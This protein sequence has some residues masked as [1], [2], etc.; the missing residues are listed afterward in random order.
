MRRKRFSRWPS[1]RPPHPMSQAGSCPRLRTASSISAT[2]RPSR[3][4]SLSPRWRR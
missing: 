1:A 4:K 2:A 3:S